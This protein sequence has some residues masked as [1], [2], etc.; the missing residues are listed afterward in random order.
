MNRSRFINALG[1]LA[2]AAIVAVELLAPSASLASAP[3]RVELT[4][5]AAI[6]LTAPLQAIAKLYE[7]RHPAFSVALNL[8]AS[9]ILEQQIE[10][11]APADIFISASPREMNELEKQSL[12]RAASRRNLV[13]NILVLVCPQGE[14]GITSFRNLVLPRVKRVAIANP[15]SVPAGMYAKQALE[16]FKV[17]KEVEPKLLLAGDVRQALAYAETGDADAAI[18]YL[19][20]AKLSKRVRVVATAPAASH[21]PVVYPVAVLQRSREAAAAKQ[22]VDFLSGREAQQVFEREGFGPPGKALTPSAKPPI[23]KQDPPSSRGGGESRRLTGAGARRGQGRIITEG[24][25]AA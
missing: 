23:E 10:E 17:F 2:L 19:T 4:V 20:E 11:G 16:Y 18:V 8:G 15:E 14:L 12:I 5:S 3:K 6:S 1:K 9:G 22:F 7:K 13:S 25:G 21:A 24:R